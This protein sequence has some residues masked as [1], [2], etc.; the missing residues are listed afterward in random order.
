ML[1][2][3]RAF[4]D[5]GSTWNV[6]KKLLLHDNR[7][8]LVTAYW[9]QSVS[10]IL[11]LFFLG[12]ISYSRRIRCSQN[13]G[14]ETLNHTCSYYQCPKYFWPFLAIHFHLILNDTLMVFF[15]VFKLNENITQKF[16]SFKYVI[17]FIYWFK[18]KSISVNVANTYIF[19]QFS[20]SQSWA[21]VQIPS[22]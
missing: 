16:P 12:Q 9:L 4:F 2:S 7:W 11:P 1:Q 21:K 15:Y 6:K 3:C 14:P 5:S 22:L 17:S 18:L 19:I 20:T 8:R 13:P 10:M